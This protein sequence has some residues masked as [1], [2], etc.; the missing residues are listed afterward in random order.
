M[1][2]N[3]H[4]QTLILFIILIPLMLIVMAFVV[5]IGLVMSEKVH[6]K[7]TTKIAIINNYDSKNINDIKELIKKN[8]IDINNLK[9]ETN[10]NNLTI[11]NEIKVESIFGKIIGLNNYRIKIKAKGY[12]TGNKVIVEF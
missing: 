6:L 2:L 3:K 4:G 8:N 10:N 5:D 12:K 9:I 7:E 1:L 11:E